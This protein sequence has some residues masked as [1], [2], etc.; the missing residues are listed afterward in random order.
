MKRSG[1]G[2]G[3]GSSWEIVWITSS[4]SSSATRTAVGG[5]VSS[6]REVGLEMGVFVEYTNAWEGVVGVILRQPVRINRAIDEAKNIERLMG[7]GWRQAKSA[8]A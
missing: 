1:S 5:A 6:G 3:D 8:L 2:A 4:I 7:I